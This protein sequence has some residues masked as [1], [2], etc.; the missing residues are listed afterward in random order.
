M[1]QNRATLQMLHPPLF[2][3]SWADVKQ[4]SNNVPV[5]SSFPGISDLKTYM[6]AQRVLALLIHFSKVIHFH[7]LNQVNGW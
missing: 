2:S 4:T 6:K 1:D 5:Y 3:S 7:L